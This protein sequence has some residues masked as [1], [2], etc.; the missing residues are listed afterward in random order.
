M[1]H[2]TAVSKRG[3]IHYF[4]ERKDTDKTPIVF[5][6]GLIADHRMFEMQE[7]H[8]CK[9]RTVITWDVPMHGLSCPYDGF[10]YKNAAE[11]LK[12]ILDAE[13]IDHAALAGVSMGGYICQEFADMYPG[14]TDC[15]IAIDSTPFGL[16]YYS[17]S[18]KKWLRRVAPLAAK[19]PEKF[20]KKRIAKQVGATYYANGKMMEML[21]DQTR[22]DICR[23]M[24]IAYSQFL[25]ENRDI[26]LSCPVLLL[27]GDRDKTGKVSEYTMSWAEEEG[28]PLRVISSAAHFSNG[29]NPTEVN[30]AIDEFLD[31]LGL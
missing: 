25:D 11:E 23:R 13:S 12:N 19:L 20:L 22:E 9:T 28:Y 10:T 6:H 16:S 14:R 26:E 15:F 30:D 8:F 2:R 31:G 29:D 1:E 18:D 17:E 5:T 21:A 7:E 4:T 27:L 3:E 24:D